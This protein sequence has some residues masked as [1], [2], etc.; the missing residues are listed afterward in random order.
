MVTFS[1]LLGFYKYSVLNFYS[2]IVVIHLDL[3]LCHQE[4]GF[5]F[6]TPIRKPFGGRFIRWTEETREGKH[7]NVK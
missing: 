5:A 1:Q 2:S 4:V 7:L 6:Y 3:D